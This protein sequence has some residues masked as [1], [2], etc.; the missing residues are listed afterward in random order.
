MRAIESAK[1]VERMGGMKRRL[2]LLNGEGGMD[3]LD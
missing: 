3:E 2:P 1:I